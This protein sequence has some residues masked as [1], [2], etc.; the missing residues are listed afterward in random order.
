MTILAAPTG[1]AAASVYDNTTIS[2]HWAAS[3]G[4]TGYYVYRGTSANN[5]SSTALNSLAITAT[6]YTD[7]T[8]S[9]NT[10]YYYTVVAVNA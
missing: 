3:S 4:A 8:T 5:E 2:L 6:T 1:L 10:C 9:G 7:T